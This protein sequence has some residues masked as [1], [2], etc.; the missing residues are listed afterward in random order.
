M[1]QIRGRLSRLFS[2]LPT[3]VP[4]LT[5]IARSNQS[6]RSSSTRIELC[7]PTETGAIDRIALDKII[8]F[9]LTNIRGV[10]VSSKSKLICKKTRNRTF[11]QLAK[12]INGA[13]NGSNSQPTYSDLSGFSLTLLTTA[14]IIC[15]AFRWCF[16]KNKLKARAIKSVCFFS[17]ERLPEEIARKHTLFA[18]F[19]ACF[20][21]CSL[22]VSDATVR[23][24][25]EPTPVVQ[26]GAVR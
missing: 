11:T 16:E 22:A 17:S 15:W 24:G 5:L 2:P 9:T 14:D 26:G 12:T 21:V 1:I 7:L 23:G 3:T 25:V 19:E 18:Y 8:L 13:L 4:A 10:H 6:F 20:Q